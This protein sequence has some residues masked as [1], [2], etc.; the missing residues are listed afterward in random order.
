MV[1]H[2]D[3]RGTEPLAMGVAGRLGEAFRQEGFPGPRMAKKH[4]GTGGGDAVEVAQGQE[5]GFLLLAGCMVLEVALVARPFFGEGGLAPPEVDGVVPAVLQCEVRQER[6]RRDHMEVALHGVLQRG[7]ELL[8]HACETE[9]GACVLQALGV[10]PTRVLLRTK[11]SESA[12]VGS[13]RRRALRGAC[14][15]RTGGCCRWGG[16]SW[17]RRFAIEWAPKA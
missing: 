15:S 8:E 10:R 6:E 9:V 17:E 11:A 3:G 5:T 13:A 14:V 16:I 12:R 7:V 4:D 2:V 1:E